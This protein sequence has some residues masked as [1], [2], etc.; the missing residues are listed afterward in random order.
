[1]SGVLP[2]LPHLPSWQAEEIHFVYRMTLI[3]I[4]TSCNINGSDVY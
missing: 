1:M 4:Q 3:E 2:I